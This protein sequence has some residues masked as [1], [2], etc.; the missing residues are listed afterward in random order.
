MHLARAK[1]STLASAIAAPILIALNRGIDK[2]FD[3][4]CIITILLGLGC[5]LL[6][7]WCSKKI[8]PEIW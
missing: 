3:P 4:L 6:C 7:G 5:S 8:S 1:G 2:L